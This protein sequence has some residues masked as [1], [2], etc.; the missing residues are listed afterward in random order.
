MIRTGTFALRLPKSTRFQASNFAKREGVSLN[1][2]IVLA[3]GEKI[4][5]MEAMKPHGETADRDSSA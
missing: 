2:F 1:Q 5:R 3:V 4:I